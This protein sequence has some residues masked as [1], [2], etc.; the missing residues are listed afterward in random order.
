M[1][2]VGRAAARLLALAAIALGPACRED[3]SPAAKP[4]ERTRPRPNILW[5]VWDTVRADHMSLY[6]YAKQT[7]PKLDAWAKGARVYTDCR[8][9][10]GYTTASHASMFTGLMPG[11]HGTHNDREY[12]EDCHE[13][14]AELLKGAGYQTYAYSAN[15]NVAHRTNLAQGFEIIEHP[16]DEALLGEAGALVANKLPEGDTS[17]ELP[18]KFAT[19][20]V[21][22][23]DVKASGVLQE[24]RLANWLQRRDKARP[25]LAFLNYMEAH[26]PYIPPRR[27]REQVMTPEQVEASYRVDRSKLPIWEYTFGLRDYAPEELAV[28]AGTYD[29]TL[30]ELDDLFAGL[31]K[32]LEALGELDNTVII[33]TSDHGELLGEHHMLDHQYSLHEPL[34]QVPLVV[35][36]PPVFAAG[37]ENAPVMSLDLYAT[38][39]ELASVKA[40][41]GGTWSIPLQ[42]PQAGRT[43]LAEDRGTF[44]FGIDTVKAAHPHFDATPWRRDL[45]SFVKGPTKFIWGA[46]GRHELYELS[47][48]PRETQNLATSQQ[49]RAADMARQMETVRA[50]LR[51]RCDPSG[52]LPEHTAAERRVLDTFG[53]MGDAGA[54]PGASRDSAAGDRESDSPGDDDE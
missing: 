34:V 44:Q 3:D 29:A 38:I 37:R 9:A 19:G 45:A 30:L 8:S 16:W 33:V 15:P 36:Y 42:R 49:D 47:S 26:R 18:E 43:R 35:H 23:S 46:D 17:T 24:R 13:T 21:G 11:E 25:W 1:R 10:A 52:K 12:L 54:D 31:L 39:L 50:M 14:V 6:G 7:T 4:P 22:R 53:Y 40:P 48:D 27:Y 28:I 20:A 2:T 32:R 51:L 41:P 5:V